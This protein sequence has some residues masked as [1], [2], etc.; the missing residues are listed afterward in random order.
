MPAWLAADFVG[1]SEEMS[2][3]D[4]FLAGQALRAL[5]VEGDP[6]IGKTA[7]LRSAVER[8]RSVGLDVHTARP[9][10]VETT[11]SFAALR[12]LL[13]DVPL[14]ARE[15]LPQIQR[16]ALAVALAEEDPG[17]AVTDG[18]TLA[19]AIRGLLE[20]LALDR[21]VLLAIDDLQWLDEPTAT[22]LVYALRRLADADVRLL[23]TRRGRALDPL[24]FGLDSALGRTALERLELG[25]LSEGAIRRMV[26]LKLGSELTR[27][28]LHALYEA[29]GGNPLYSLELFRS[30][31]ELDD[32]GALRLP[33]SLD[34]LAARRLNRLPPSTREALLCVAALADP[35][36]DLL[37]RAGVLRTLDAALEADVLEVDDHRI[38]F[39]H[40]LLRAAAWHAADP[41]QRM[42]VHRRL[43]DVVDDVEER[44]RH[45]AAIAQPP[46]AAIADLL[47]AAAGV[48][49]QRGAPASAAELLDAA[50]HLAPQDERER[51]ARLAASAAL[52]HAEAGHWD[53]VEHIVELAE[54]LP[55]GPPHAAILIAATEMRPGLDSLLWQAVSEAGETP[56][57]VQARV[58]LAAQAAFAGKWRTSV[59]GAEDAVAIARRLGSRPLLGVAL[60]YLGGLKLLDTRLEGSREIAEALRIEHELGELPATVF[61]TPRMWSA[62]ALA[63]RD[64][65]DGARPLLEEQITLASERGDDLKLMQATLFQ[66]HFELRAGEW[67]RARA[68]GEMALDLVERF[69]YVYERPIILG[70]LAAL[71]ACEG[72]LDR[73]RAL[74]EESA[75]TLTALG[76][77][78][79][80]TF[81]LSS[82]LLT[83]HCAG[84]HS[85]ALAY[86]DAISARFPDGRES[87]WTH[88]QGDEL[89]ALVAA[90]ELERA[91]TRID[92]MRRAAEELE[93][94][95]FHIWAERGE[96]LL[97]AAEGDLRSATESLESALELHGRYRS[98]FEHARTLLAHGQ[99]LRRS[100]RRHDARVVLIEAQ[101]EF[102]RLGARHYSTAVRDELK[103]VGGRAPAGEH[104]L[105]GAEDRIA[106]LVASGLSNRQVADEL[107][108]TVSTVEAALTRV[109]RK[110]G[111]ASRS[112]LRDALTSDSPQTVGSSASSSRGLQ[113]SRAEA[114]VLP[115]KYGKAGR[116]KALS[117]RGLHA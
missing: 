84:N 83:E 82:L 87:W 35:R 4:R 74:G 27:V 73:A 100:K 98:P 56:V 48:A 29:T 47:E 46:D 91:S 15:Q 10:M 5:V 50:R 93:L 102:D 19:V 62:L 101:A 65:L 45:L 111:I 40:P 58:G 41:R 112:H 13:S 44:A 80:S 3:V 54:Q 24:P 9:A 92:A 116:T 99:V 39:A 60:S 11:L 89:A 25:P 75:S 21:P 66:I 86:A 42:D 30:G 71:E 6:G 12:D 117:G 52:A 88:H 77:R 55:P 67:T 68:L 76:D 61:V 49:Q 16:H 78:L 34:E 108:V 43:A 81:A 85:A 51:W 97:R 53:Q 33:R 8:A 105:T 26:R 31:V 107:F 95:R 17:S 110:L 18:G 37:D 104:E 14:S 22:V 36:L 20:R 64:D 103:H 28:E 79:W 94:V 57:G 114:S 2:V 106:R 69:E 23:A 72:D 7:V 1:R 109:Y 96:G 32:S 63:S 38:R 115:S 70:A 59:E 90:G 113:P